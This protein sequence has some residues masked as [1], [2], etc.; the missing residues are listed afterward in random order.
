MDFY[1]FLSLSL[2]VCNEM[3]IE[4]SSADYLLIVGDEDPNASMNSHVHL[5]KRFAEPQ[6]KERCEVV[7]YAGAGHLI[8][9]PF[10][11]HSEMSYL[12]LYG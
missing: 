10:A 7:T 9:P 4:K 11:P 3:Q 1:G 12:R 2:I 5:Q 8:E 6:Q